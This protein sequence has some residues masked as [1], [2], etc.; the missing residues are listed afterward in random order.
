MTDL[1]ELIHAALD[2]AYEGGYGDEMLTDTVDNVVISLIDYDADIGELRPDVM[3]VIPH[4]E[5]WRTSRAN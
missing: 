1:R 4:V 3:D 5:S 2:N